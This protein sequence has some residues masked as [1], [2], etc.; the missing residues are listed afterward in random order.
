MQIQLT[1]N[2]FVDTGLYV[3]AY[4]AKVESPEQLS[5]DAIQNVHRDGKELARTNAR[6]KS[7]TMVF[8][9]NGPLTQTGYRPTGKK[10][11]LSKKNI[12]AYTGVLGAFL[13]QMQQ[14]SNNYPLCEICGTEYGFDFDQTVRRAFADA[15]IPDRGIKQVGREWFPLAGSTGNDAQALPSASRGL[16]I[17]AKCLFAVHYMPQGLMLMQ[18]RLVCFQ[19]NHPRIAFELTAD[20]VND[21]R[22]RLGATTDKIEMIGKKEGTTAVTRRLINWMRKLDRAKKEEQLPESADLLIWLFT[23]AGADADCEIVQVPNIALQFL[24]QARQ[25]GFEKELLALITGESKFPEYQLLSCVRGRQDYPRL[26][27]YKTFPGAEPKFFALYHQLILGETSTALQSAQKLAQA[28]L[29]NAKPKEQK[30]LKKAGAIDSDTKEWSVIRRMMLDMS[31]RGDFISADYNSLFPTTQYHP[32]RV[33][34]R[35]WKTIGYYISHPTADIPDYS[36]LIMREEV[37]MRPHPKINQL[38]QLYFQDFMA[39][40]GAKRF[41][42]EILDNFRRTNPNGIE[43]LRDLYIRF[44]KEYP[45][46]QYKDWDDFVLD[47]NGQP[48]AGELLFQMRLELANLFREYTETRTKSK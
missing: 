17:C 45:D 2:P 16:S 9:T 3:L 38:A 12:A 44:A 37:R 1:G 34:F 30:A 5:L 32:I 21:Y 13:S 4:L 41:E 20:L 29:A 40:K 42:R 22:E 6:L 43:W 31:K 26:Y 27:P 11:E 24:W 47:E 48:Q 35:G 33:A 7:F 19:S 46:F 15:E 10:K 8:G 25:L 36:N 18:G 23:N 39:K 28:R 14:P